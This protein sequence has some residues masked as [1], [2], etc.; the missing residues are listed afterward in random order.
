M[1]EPTAGRLALILSLGL[2]LDTPTDQ[3][4][5]VTLNGRVVML[6]AALKS[7]GLSFD[8]E[9]IARQVVLKGADGTLTPILSDEASRALFLDQRLR[10]RSTEIKGRRY[11]GNP[12][13]QV[14]TFRIEENGRLQ[15]P[16]YYCEI[17]TISVRY[18]QICPC[19]QGPMELRMK[20][21]SR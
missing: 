16:E 5:P 19:C 14:L 20:P 3:V 17:C 12:Y 21:D 2:V 4:E 11:P 13:I 6:S 10:D 18:P 15:T 8:T 7:S 9:P 1:I